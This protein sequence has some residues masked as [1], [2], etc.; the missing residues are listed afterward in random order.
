ML[1]MNEKLLFLGW[2]GSTYICKKNHCFVLISER[3][4]IM[5]SYNPE[6]RATIIRHGARRGKFPWPP[7]EMK[8]SPTPFTSVGCPPALLQMIAECSHSHP[9]KQT[10]P[11]PNGTWIAQ[12]FTSSFHPVWQN[13]TRIKCLCSSRYCDT[14]HD[15]IRKD[16]QKNIL[17]SKKAMDS[18]TL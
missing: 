3:V 17:F 16:S 4:S 18:E 5:T 9:H 14:Y 15:V 12:T 2:A 6:L 1:R 11:D 13:F 8:L 7:T 10:L